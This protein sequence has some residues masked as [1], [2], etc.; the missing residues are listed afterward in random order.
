MKL[1]KY[2]ER[3][4][5]VNFEQ[6]I[7]ETINAQVHTLNHQILKFRGVTST[8]P[9]YCSLTIMFDNKLT[10]FKTLAKHIT[11]LDL[12]KPTLI[13]SRSLKI[14]VCYEDKYGPDLIALEEQLKLD[15]KRIIELHQAQQYKVYMM[16]FL[17]GFGYLGKLPDA[18]KC[19]RKSNPRKQVPAQSVGIAG[20]QTGIYPISAPGGWQIIGRT[21]IPLVG[22]NFNQGILLQ[23]G[24]SV[25]F[26]QIQ[27][28]EFS[29]IS[30][31]VKN[32]TYNFDELYV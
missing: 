26:R 25:K 13:E 3:A 4:V 14:P 15:K 17:P 23:A 28:E 27:E 22:K 18:L 24:D 12:S 6:K 11:E 29:E 19:N 10:D 32:K 8:I 30:N 2:G 21:P 9:A 16:G 5:L 1:L 7:D 31:Q 20:L